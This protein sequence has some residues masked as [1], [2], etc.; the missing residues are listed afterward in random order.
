M[1]LIAAILAAHAECVLDAA[2]TAA[3]LDARSGR[4]RDRRELYVD[5]GEPDC[6]RISIPAE[7]GARLARARVR[8]RRPDRQL[9]PKDRLFRTAEGW[10]V[11]LPEVRSG[12]LVRLDLD[13]ATDPGA[14]PATSGPVVTREIADSIHLVVDRTWVHSTRVGTARTA[15]LPADAEKAWCRIGV[16]MFGPADSACDLR[17]DGENRMQ[18]GWQ[19]AGRRRAGEWRPEGPGRLVLA[20]G[21]FAVSVTGEVRVERGETSVAVDVGPGGAVEWRDAAS[22]PDRAALLQEVALAA[23]TASMPEPGL[24]LEFKGRKKDPT[25]VDDVLALVREQVVPGRLPTYHPLLPRPL[26]EARRSGWASPWEMA[27]LLTRYLRQLG[28]DALPAPVRP[29]EAGPGDPA[30]PSGWTEAAVLLRESGT[31]IAPT[32]AMCAAGE[33]PPAFDG[34]MVLAEGIDRLPAATPGSRTRTARVAMGDRLATV[35]VE[36][37]GADALALRT[38]LLALPPRDRLASIAPG[39]EVLGHEGLSTPGA[40][41]HLRLGGVPLDGTSLPADWPVPDPEGP[42]TAILPWRTSWEDRIT[43]EGAALLPETVERVA[44]GL[45]WTRTVSVDSVVER[46]DVTSRTVDRAETV[47]FFAEIASLRAASG[48]DTP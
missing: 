7:E 44:P 37:R 26:A 14:A 3:R 46:L 19:E 40:S 12:D 18:W 8:I 11:L 10:E 25:A 15:P 13:W 22:I 23:I 47:G 2:E 28:I 48:R 43:F 9:R 42:A 34:A 20:G 36:L 33:L 24:P 38:R 27:L 30:M 4:R 6:R 1:T 41:V 17:F 45:R 31:W 5:L 32:C 29:V 21:A 39:A 35:E 16:T